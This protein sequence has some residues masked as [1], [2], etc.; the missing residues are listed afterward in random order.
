MIW[1]NDGRRIILALATSLGVVGCYTG[2]DPENAAVTAAKVVLVGPRPLGTVM[3]ALPEGVGL[4]GF[5]VQFEAGRQGD[6]LLTAPTQ[7]I[8]DALNQFGVARKKLHLA[9]RKSLTSPVELARLDEL[10]AVPPSGESIMVN[11]VFADG[12]RGEIRAFAASMEGYFYE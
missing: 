11:M 2:Q 4:R 12:P 10:E 1:C 8:D 5:T 6:L 9:L 7:S 3:E